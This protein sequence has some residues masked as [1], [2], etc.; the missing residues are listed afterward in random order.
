VRAKDDAALREWITHWD[1]LEA[2]VVR[3]YRGG[4]ATSSDEQIYTQTRAWLSQHLP[5]WQAQL[6]P[7]WHGRLIGGVPATS[8]PFAKLILPQHA[9]EFVGDRTMMQTL[10]AAREALNLFI[11]SRA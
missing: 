11:L 5:S 8:D 1:T 6:Q 7:H 3:V 9:S 2:L 10:P 4:T